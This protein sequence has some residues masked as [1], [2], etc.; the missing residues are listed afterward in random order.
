VRTVKRDT[1]IAALET[2]LN[3]LRRHDREDAAETAEGRFRTALRFDYKS[4]SYRDPLA[5]MQLEDTTQDD[6]LEWCDRLRSGRL[7]R[8]VNRLVRAVSAGLNRANRLGHIGN[9]TTWRLEAL[10]DDDEVETAVF[11]TRAQRSR[12]IAAAV[13]AAAAFLRGLELSGAR[14]KE[15]S[16]ATAGDF[17]GER[18]K[19]S[20]R[21]GRRRN[22]AHGMSFWTRRESPSS[23]RRQRTSCRQRCCLRRTVEDPGA[24]INGL[25]KSARRSLRTTR[26]LVDRIA[27]RVTRPLTA[28]GTLESV[29]CCRSTEWIR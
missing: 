19:L 18:L 16:A 17:D 14:P 11:L 3:D 13:P 9:P 23:N 24:A 8:T 4:K 7:P 5:G 27:S 28:S 1:V 10:P 21:K 20:H 12:L 26:L 22:C 29:S 25:T 6:F 15:L 2:Y